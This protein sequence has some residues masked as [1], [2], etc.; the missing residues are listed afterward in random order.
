MR[1]NLLTVFNY[2]NDIE[3][4][5]Y[6]KKHLIEV[7]ESNSQYSYK[8]KGKTDSFDTEKFSRHI[9]ILKNSMIITDYNEKEI[10]NI[11]I[12]ESNNN[13]NYTK[14]YFYSILNNSMNYLYFK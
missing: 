10:F 12:I 4:E 1:I 2:V 3:N 9:K 8:F 6:W 5:I 14:I 7:S 11:I 13:G